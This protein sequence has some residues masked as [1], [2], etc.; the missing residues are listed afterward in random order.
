M[1]VGHT[2][3]N[4]AEGSSSSLEDVADRTNTD[5]PSTPV[6]SHPST[7]AATVV[8][9]GK[10][11][12]LGSNVKNWKQRHYIILNNGNLRYYDIGEVKSAASAAQDK[13]IKEF[14]L[15][16]IT[17]EEGSE[18]NLTAS[19]CADFSAEH[20]V[21]ITITSFGIHIKVLDVVFDTIKEA[22]VFVQQVKSVSSSHNVEVNLRLRVVA[23]VH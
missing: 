13:G 18:R 21:A 20:G 22:K 16:S 12:K 19:G 1:T 2:S 5:S 8:G 11:R 3:A 17:L 14:C 23:V 6:D 9:E 7:L 10:F 4:G 15:A